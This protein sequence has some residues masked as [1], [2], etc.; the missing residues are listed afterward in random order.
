MR[1]NGSTALPPLAVTLGE[2]MKTA[3][4]QTGAFIGA[5]ILD[6]A[7]GFD[8]GFDHFDSRF[9]RFESGDKLKAER[10]AERVVEP[11]LEWLR[12]VPADRPFFAWVHFYD[13][14]APYTAPGAI[15]QKF[16]QRPY[17]GEIAY[18][19]QA[20]GRLVSLLEQRSLLERTL[21]VAVGDHGESL[22]QHGEEDHG[23]FLYDATLSVPWIMRFPG[24]A[25]AG[26]VVREQVRSVDVMPT[27]LDALGVK[28]VP[29]VDGE[30]VL[31][32]V[33]GKP[34]PA[35]PLSYAE[36]FYP[37]L[38]FGWSELRSARVGEW[39]LVDAPR[40][41]LY[42]LRVD[43]REAS[44]IYTR[45]PGVAGR[46]SADLRSVA[47]NVAGTA[48]SQP[49]APPDAETLERLRSLGYV[50]LFRPLT[51][52][53]PGGRPQ[54]HGAKAARVPEADDRGHRHAAARAS[55]RS[56]LPAE[57][58]ACDQ[59]AG[60]RRPPRR[61]ATPTCSSGSWSR[62]S[63][64]TTP[65]RSCTRRWPTRCWPP[66]VSSASR[67]ASTGLSRRLNRRPESSR[68]HTRS[69]WHEDG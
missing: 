20:V 55:G 21:V 10:T 48:R 22:G 32:V 64:S 12:R 57:A 66:P 26:V 37:K 13:A 25:Q 24:R 31:A 53:R 34:R 47:D 5:F 44:N 27:L 29:G 59:R 60:L 36:T 15:G 17:D 1:D 42:D 54:G 9:E 3:G 51:C 63:G 50:G 61:S 39:K 23:L 68:F 28:G 69:R 6:R 45:Q 4:Y 52:R 2:T 43:R 18:V 8:Q 33:R 67:D 16:R 11:A 46:L 14:H 62:P 49:A 56:R 19:N 30:S 40:P 41:E 65:P 38:H 7:Y 35:P 58:G